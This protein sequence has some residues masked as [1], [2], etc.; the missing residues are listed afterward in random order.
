MLSAHSQYGRWGIIAASTPPQPRFSLRAARSA[1]LPEAGA[2]RPAP[3]ASVADGGSP[4]PRGALANG[5][6]GP[7][8]PHQLMG[9]CLLTGAARAAALG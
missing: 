6:A 7:P 4:V 8:R 9:Q 2:L 1:A 5:R 3:S